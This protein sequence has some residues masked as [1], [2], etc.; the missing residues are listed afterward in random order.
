MRD[1]I[2]IN[3]GMK[4]HI[5]REAWDVKLK[6][7]V[8]EFKT[9]VRCV[10]NG[11]EGE[12]YNISPCHRRFNPETVRGIEDHVDNYVIIRYKSLGERETL[13]RVEMKY[14]EGFEIINNQK[15]VSHA[16]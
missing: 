6:E 1:G 14:T 7:G 3:L 13:V 15:E 8:L 9:S 10:G 11:F 5:Y 2:R 16:V 12:G 4:S